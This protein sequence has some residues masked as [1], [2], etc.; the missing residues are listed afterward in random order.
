MQN[1]NGGGWLALLRW[2][3]YL[4]GKG[5]R[6]SSPRNHFATSEKL[7]DFKILPSKEEDSKA[8]FH[9]PSKTL[10]LNLKPLS[11]AWPSVLKLNYEDPSAKTL[12]NVILLLIVMS[13]LGCF[14]TVAE[15]QGGKNGLVSFIYRCTEMFQGNLAVQGHTKTNDGQEKC[16]LGSKLHHFQSQSQYQMRQHKNKELRRWEDPEESSLLMI[17]NHSSRYAQGALRL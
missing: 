13:S 17:E 1:T 16:S 10:E 2:P 14:R 4:A 7:L 9:V 5:A 15:M 6:E 11:L 12:S 8:F 3:K